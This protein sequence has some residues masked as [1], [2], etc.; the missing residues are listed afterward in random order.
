MDGAVGV[1][2]EQSPE[3]MTFYHLK[4]LAC[5]ATIASMFLILYDFALTIGQEI[6]LIWRSAWSPPKLVYL[7]V[8]PRAKSA[9][10]QPILTRLLQPSRLADAQ[11]PDVGIFTDPGFMLPNAL[12]GSPSGM[13]LYQLSTWYA[14]LS[15]MM[16]QLVVQ[17]WL[18]ALFK[19][20]TVSTIL[21]TFVT[22]KLK[23][24]TCDRLGR[25]LI[26]AL[27]AAYVTLGALTFTSIYMSMSQLRV[28]GH[29][30]VC[31]AL[32][33][34]VAVGPSIKDLVYAASTSTN[35]PPFI[36]ATLLPSLAYSVFMIGL[37]TYKAT[38]TFYDPRACQKYA[39][40][41][42][43]IRDSSI[44]CLIIAFFSIVNAL[45]ITV[46]PHD[47]IQAGVG[48]GIAVPSIAS[49]RMLLDLRD[50]DRKRGRVTDVQGV[51]V[52]QWET[53]FHIS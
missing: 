28:V 35:I 32:R 46:M 21:S 27:A 42:V 18:Y 15:L 3:V 51:P 47:L 17:T 24:P 37:L 4:E 33:R 19:R 43:L 41:T 5:D 38:A 39:L 13:A 49:S 1:L 31:T 48:F 30:P 6:E 9:S 22:V 16:V 11:H 25:C 40:A 29:S 52:S 10:I 36:E 53:M 2:T 50:V 20:S 26:Y 8:E 23:C 14:W 7:L 45:L 34:D 44:C 12:H